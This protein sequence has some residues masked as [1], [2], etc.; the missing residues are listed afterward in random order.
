MI[1]SAAIALCLIFSPLVGDAPIAAMLHATLLRSSPAAN[2]RLAQPPDTIRLVFSEPVVPSLSQI[3]LIDSAGNARRLEVAG[4][5]R[6]VRVL[7]GRV[8]A[9]PRGQ[10]KVSWR[11]L[12][13]DGHPI[14]GSFSFFV[15]S[16][17][18]LTVA[19]AASGPAPVLRDSARRDTLL[20][21]SSGPTH[22]DASAPVLASVLRG[23][24]LGA[25]M[26]GLGLL[27]FGVTAGEHRKHAPRAAVVRLIGI[28]AILLLGHM[29]AWMVH[30]SP[31]RDISGSF[32]ASVLGSTVGQTEL[33]RVALALLA[34]FAI[35]LARREVLA[36]V[37][38]GAC[39]LVSGA[40]GHPAAIQPYLSIP[41]KMAHLL[42]A[43][44]WLGGLLWLAWLSRCDEMACRAEAR[45]VSS[46]ALIAVI[47][48]FLTG[49]LETLL[50]IN[51]PGDLIRADYG[52][53]VLLKVLGLVLLVGAGAYNRFA[54][55]PRLEEPGTTS[56][57]SRSVRNE[58][59][60]VS[61]VIL[62]G[63]FLGYVPTPPA[64]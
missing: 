28:G 22:T 56:R 38:G 18:T 19:P 9:I 49:S 37:F 12:S 29:F 52:R 20:A 5:T 23:T 4:D 45:R 8:G 60:I 34:F 11:I 2:S 43:S 64:P 46:V 14:A 59:V 3:S 26:A 15:E 53:L 58:I 41:A 40:V 42:S 62:I 25:L 10:Y 16:A 13:A 39:L 1:R 36:V 54:L 6:N 17:K 48:I 50:F 21:S 31:T 32:I 47:A 57:L 35:A 51:F 63:G 24:G 7:V 30:I 44:L 27:F 33:L 55:V 61:I